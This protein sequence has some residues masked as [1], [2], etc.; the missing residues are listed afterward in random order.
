M[1]ATLD[2][3]PWTCP[4]CALLCDRFGVAQGETLTPAGTSCPRA[5]RA[6]AQFGGTPSSA[7]PAVNGQPVD[8]QT[9]LDTAA[10]WLARARQPLFG[11]MA[12]DVAGARALYR[13]A[14]ACGAIVDHAH[15][16]ALMHGL[17][18]M[19]DRGAFTT[20]FAEIRNRADL[21][22]CIGSSP[23]TRYP[24]FFSRCA[25][26]SETGGETD[27]VGPSQRT[28]VFLG[29][30]IDAALTQRAG[31]ETLAVP[32]QGDLYDTV[33]MLNALLAGK[34]LRAPADPALAALVERMLAA[35]YTAMVWIPADLPGAHAALLVEGL[36][37]LLKTL[38]R[39]RRAGGLALGGDD[40]G[41]SVNQALTWLSGLPLRTGVHRSGLEH[42]PQ[43]YDTAR[44][45]ADRD[46]DAL[47]WVASF[48]A[49]LPPPRTPLPTIVLGHPGLAAACA[50][51]EG[52]TV[53]VPVST[54]GIG[55]A[56]H[57]FRA[58]GGVVLPLTPIYAD[59]LPTVAAFAAQLDAKLASCKENAA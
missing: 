42:A 19:Q 15:G 20:T 44:L 50:D 13:V 25:V 27:G 6:L 35:D 55:S 54:P 14:N 29:C 31:V 3:P 10:Q 53:F 17:T 45:L 59:T 22:V 12:T 4:F 33:A 16:R 43:R 30:E 40:G 38:N 18:A 41:A 1:D 48:G 28:V 47:V 8:A 9:A 37:R 51:R 46:V 52:P 57:L 24:E 32:L 26:G 21:I 49:D 5:A 36:D 58:D 56:G 23:S 2:T 7:T 11:G 34:S 39:M